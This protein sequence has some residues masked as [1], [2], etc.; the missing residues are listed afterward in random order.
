MAGMTGTRKIYPTDLAWIAGLG[1]QRSVCSLSRIPISGG[2][3]GWYPC[4]LGTG[5]GRYSSVREQQR[6]QADGPSQGVMERGN[7]DAHRPVH[8]KARRP[9]PG[10]G[11]AGPV[12]G[13]QGGRAERFSDPAPSRWIASI[14]RENAAA[15]PASRLTRTCCPARACHQSSTGYSLRG[16][17]GLRPL[18]IPTSSRRECVD[19]PS[20]SLIMRI[21]TT[22]E[23][24]E[25]VRAQAGCPFWP[26]TEDPGSDVI[27]RRETFR[28]NADRMPGKYQIPFAFLSSTKA[29]QVTIRF[30]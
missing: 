15:S 22:G 4:E 8:C 19:R 24:R 13:V 10:T 5:V 28:T 20:G 9:R 18:F 25:A 16:C 6:T 23:E 30:R 12:C 27:M 2:V 3:I 26:H 14:S 29:T 1:S 11:T 7:P 17:G 21:T